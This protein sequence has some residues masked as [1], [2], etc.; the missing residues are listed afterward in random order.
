MTFKWGCSANQRLPLPWPTKAIGQALPSRRLAPRLQQPLTP[1]KF[2]GGGGG[3][4]KKGGGGGK[5]GKTQ[6]NPALG[7]LQILTARRSTGTPQKLNTSHNG[8]SKALPDALSFWPMA[9]GGGGGGPRGG[10]PP[11]QK[12]KKKKKKTPPPRKLGL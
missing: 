5:R 8:R 12:Q 11:P 3:G 4:K 9:K 7:M 10:A 2:G 6:K 1:V